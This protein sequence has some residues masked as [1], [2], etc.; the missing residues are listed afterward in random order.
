MAR[1]NP[2]FEKAGMQTPKQFEWRDRAYEK[3][4]REL[5][6]L[7]FD[8]NLVYSKSYS[9]SMLKKLGKAEI[10]RVKKFCLTYCLTEKFRPYASRPLIE[11]GDLEALAQAFKLLRLPTVYFIWKNPHFAGYPDP[12]I[13]P[14]G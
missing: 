13:L 7:G 10:E 3:G 11:R 14:H 6:E 1:Y 5:E 4:L 8:L 12:C 9:L 2:F